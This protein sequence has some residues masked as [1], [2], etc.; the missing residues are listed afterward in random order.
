MKKKH[1]IALAVCSIATS[2]SFAVG[3][4]AQAAAI[5]QQQSN[6]SL[7][8]NLPSTA[9]SFFAPIGYGPNWGVMYGSIS[10]VNRWPGGHQADGSA[11]VGAGLGN[12]DRYLGG[13]I[14]YLIDSV[15]LN[16]PFAQNSALSGAVTRWLNPNTSIA[17]GAGRI[18]GSGAFE[19]T[20]YNLFAAGTHLIPLTPNRSYSTPVA[21][22]VGFGS[23]SFVSFNEMRLAHRDGPVQAFGALS[24]SPIEQ[25]S[26]VA[27]YTSQILSCGLSIIP[28]KRI[29]LVVAGYATNIAGGNIL[30]GPVTYGLRA[31]FG[32]A[33]A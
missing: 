1:I 2:T 27:D 18:F 3:A 17:V 20:S 22:T 4:T 32:V 28:F 11:L 24:V 13:S 5:D 33:F 7:H 31:G 25:L 15:G 19:A 29:P 21:V 14:N 26:L 23:G 30:P 12:S 9:I 16:E 6:V 8:P 10:G